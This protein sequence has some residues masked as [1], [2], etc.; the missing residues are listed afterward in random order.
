MRKNLM[1]LSLKN[2]N[3]DEIKNIFK[4]AEKTKKIELIKF[5][6]EKIEGF[7][8]NVSAR[9]FSNQTIEGVMEMNSR[10]IKALSN[11]DPDYVAKNFELNLK[12]LKISEVTNIPKERL[13]ALLFF[14]K[15]EYF[16]E[17]LSIFFE[18]E[19]FLDGGKIQKAN[20]EKKMEAAKI[21]GKFYKKHSNKVSLGDLSLIFGTS[22]ISMK[23]Y[24]GKHFSERCKSEPTCPYKRSLE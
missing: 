21:L 10:A 15:E 13:S 2:L 23:N 11:A 3:F 17:L 5:I 18:I 8:F 7:M 12:A 22:E 6:L 14:E 19:S 24:M 4:E 1:D 20:K 9:S 16:E